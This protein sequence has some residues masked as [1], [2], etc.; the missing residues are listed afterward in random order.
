M[1]LKRGRPVSGANLVN[2]LTGSQH[3]KRRVELVLQ[4]ITGQI[5]IPQACA[6]LNI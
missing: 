1:R 6:E 4:T 3:A 5:T 2:N